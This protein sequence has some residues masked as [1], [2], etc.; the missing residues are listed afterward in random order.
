MDLP[1]S[2]STEEKPR[3]VSKKC[4]VAVVAVLIP[5]I[6]LISFAFN[7]QVETSV[8]TVIGKIFPGPHVKIK[9]TEVKGFVD[10]NKVDHLA[11]IVR[12]IEP[13]TSG[14]RLTIEWEGDEKVVLI[15]LEATVLFGPKKLSEQPEGNRFKQGEVKEIKVD[16]AVMLNLL[17]N[18]PNGEIATKFVTVVR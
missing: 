1:T 14:T 4:I 6:I 18:L 15:D 12:N 7:K 10:G 13:S 5:L 3:F 2:F 8:Y 16:D 11:G 17:E 9:G